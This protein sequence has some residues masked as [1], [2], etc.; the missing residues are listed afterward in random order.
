[1]LSNLVIATDGSEASDRMIGCLHGLRRVGS[2]NAALTHV[3]NVHHVG[4]LYESLKAAMAPRLE[5]QRTF[6]SAARFNVTVETPL[7]IPFYEIN[8]IRRVP[9]SFPRQR[10][11]SSCPAGAIADLVRASSSLS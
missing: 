9:G 5:Q 6:L 11:Q 2:T 3:F 1:M 4:G 8:K 7:G 10:R